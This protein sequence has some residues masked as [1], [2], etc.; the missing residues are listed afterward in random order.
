M[1]DVVSMSSLICRTYQLTIF[2]S[3][4]DAGVC[5]AGTMGFLCGKGACS[6]ILGLRM[7]RMVGM[8]PCFKQLYFFWLYA[9]LFLF[10]SIWFV[11]RW[12]KSMNPKT[13][14]TLPKSAPGQQICCTGHLEWGE[15]LPQLVVKGWLL[16][17]QISRKAAIMIVSLLLFL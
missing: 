6:K 2:C 16:T 15:R 10:G 9:K 12:G 3:Q 11:F 8:V 4:N 1:F 5:V 17:S 13:L 14:S 7:S